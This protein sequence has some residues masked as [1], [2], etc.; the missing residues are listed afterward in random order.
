MYKPVILNVSPLTFKMSM[1]MFIIPNTP[2]AITPDNYWYKS[3]IK[4]MSNLCAAN[5]RSFDPS[6][7]LIEMWWHNEWCDN[8]SD[9]YPLIEINGKE[10]VYRMDN[11]IYF[12]ESIA[13]MFTEGATVT[14][15]IPVTLDGRD[16]DEMINAIMETD[17]TANQLA[18]RYRRF[19]KYEEVLGRFIALD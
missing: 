18:G 19:G 1:N 8:I 9:H 3:T 2:S 13:K 4:A 15:N 6:E 12:P 11:R 17:I 10:Y 16:D 14:I 7:K 5:G